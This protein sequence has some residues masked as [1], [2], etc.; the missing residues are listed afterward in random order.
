MATDCKSVSENSRWFESSLFHNTRI[1]FLR[2]LRTFIILKWN[3]PK[4]FKKYQ[5][6]K[7]FKSLKYLKKIIKKNFLNN[8]NLFNNKHNL[9][10]I[11][12]FNIYEKNI[13]YNNIKYNNIKYYKFMNKIKY[14]SN[15][16]NTN[17]K[18]NKQMKSLFK[19]IYTYNIF[20]NSLYIDLFFFQK[21]LKLKTQNIQQNF[22]L[23][24]SFNKSKIH[25]NLINNV[26]KTYLTLTNGFFLKF[27]DKKKSFKKNKIIR[28]L[29]AK[30]I[31]KIYIICKI[32]SSNLIIKK[33]PNLLL[34]ILNI[35]NSP[36]AHKFLNPISNKLIEESNENFLWIKFSLFIFLQNINFTKNKI[37]KKGRIKRKILRKLTFENKIID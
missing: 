32:K 26:K 16:N 29:M 36:I 23:N 8:K 10:F 6:N 19:L 11:I 7:F 12:P 17:L 30:Y 20:I 1:I 21:K 27:F 37:K 3:K 33:T 15:K 18:K 25:I 9:Y 5:N 35:I 22:A 34:E 24:L 2:K 13:W 28:L 4:K 31:R 14:K